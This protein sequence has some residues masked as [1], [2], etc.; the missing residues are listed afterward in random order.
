[1]FKSVMRNAVRVL[2]RNGLNS[3][4]N[5]LGLAVSLSCCLLILL[6]VHEELSFDEFHENRDDIYR[7]VS[8]WRYQ[9]GG[10]EW[11]AITGGAPG[12]LLASDCPE[13]ESL[14]RFYSPRPLLSRGDTRIY[15]DEF[16]FADKSVFDVFS[17]ELK[18]G[19]PKTALSEPGSVV[20][21]EEAASRYFGD[22][23]P[24]GKVL[25]LDNRT[26]MTVTGILKQLP[27]NS[28]I[29]FEFLASMSTVPLFW[30]TFDQ[31]WDT[32]VWSYVLLKDGA[33]AD[34][35]ASRFAEA[36]RRHRD[37][38]ASPSVSYALQPL[39]DI[40]LHPLTVEIGPG[41]DPSTLWLYGGIAGL[42][43][44]VACVNFINLAAAQYARRMQEIGLRKVLG[45]SR[46][47]LIGQFAAESSLLILAAVILASGLAELFLPVFN[48]VTGASIS[49]DLIGNWTVAGGLIGLILFLGLL[50][51]VTP[52]FF[53]SIVRP[54]SVL[55]TSINTGGW[56]VILRRVMVAF[57]FAVSAA[58]ILSALVVYG[59][60]GYMQ[61]KDLGL[62]AQDVLVIPFDRGLLSRRH[63]AVK[64]ELVGRP[65]ILGVSASSAYPGQPS[66]NALTVKSPGAPE[67]EMNCIWVDDAYASTLALTSVY[68]TGEA[69]RLEPTGGQAFLLNESAMRLLGD[70]SIGSPLEV[71]AG[72]GDERAFEYSGPVRGIVRDF[73]FRSVQNRIAPAVMVIDPE[74][75]PHRFQYLLV[76][77]DSSKIDAGLGAVEQVYRQFEPNRPMECHF[78][79]DLISANYRSEEKFASM[80]GGACVLAFLTALTGLFG[81]VMHVTG[82]RTVEIGIRRVLGASAGQIVVHLN[83]ELLILVAVGNLVALP[84]ACYYL[85]DWL[86]NYAYRIA[87]DFRYIVEAV[88]VTIVLVSATVAYHSLK[89]ARANPLGALRHE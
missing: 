10:S 66:A 78:L 54:S 23:S 65:G 77:L 22:E 41:T 61:S 59:Q 84:V 58:L 35:V 50:T 79:Q 44:L 56:G 87:L 73:H 49:L 62:E 7:I 21:T 14:V 60:V 15:E 37:P 2:T 16:F 80:F 12:P 89:T 82:R 34:A 52:A 53:M 67:K 51:G 6:H 55:R 18:V 74:Q 71:F 57:Q 63:T 9:G 20:L 36:I 39:S 31:R 3:G 83:K 75:S 76:K 33:D 5:I 48:Q 1:M 4:I 26:E 25:T 13:I 69:D 88:A 85:S 46:G 19:D 68:D 8:H 29:R 17:F 32:P 86:N 27:D 70:I 40:H 30:S 24:M 45:A 72:T 11:K 38:E 47:Q 43:L 42:I 64:S 81:M 28:H